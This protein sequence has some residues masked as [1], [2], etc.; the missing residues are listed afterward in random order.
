MMFQIFM[1]TGNLS[2]LSLNLSNDILGHPKELCAIRLLLILC[3]DTG[4]IHTFGEV[5]N[6]MCETVQEHI[7]IKHSIIFLQKIKHLIHVIIY[8][9]HYSHPASD[10]YC[11]KEKNTGLKIL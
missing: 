7:K 1:E 5:K 3:K 8:S 4:H 11:Y 10:C 9:L 6:K 2:F